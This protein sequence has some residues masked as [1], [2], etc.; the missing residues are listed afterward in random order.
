MEREVGTIKVGVLTIFECNGE[1]K[2]YSSILN[3]TITILR[4][5]ALVLNSSGG[6]HTNGVWRI[7][8]FFVG[9]NDVTCSQ[10]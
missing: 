1:R 3:F 8:R 4:Y 6:I 5:L 2:Y 10:E 7:E 9:Q